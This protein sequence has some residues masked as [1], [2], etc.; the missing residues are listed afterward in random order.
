MPRNPSRRIF[1]ET[2]GEISIEWNYL[3]R[4]LELIAFFYLKGDSET[5]SRIFSGM[6]SG[7]FS[8]FLTYLCKKF[9]PDEGI[10]RHVL[11]SVA[12]ANILRENR[13][14]IQHAVPELS[15]DEKYLGSVHKA[16][17]I[18]AMM[19]FEASIDDLKQ[20]LQE[21]RTFKNYILMIGVCI[22][23]REQK[24]ESGEQINEDHKHFFQVVSSIDTPVLPRKINP[25][26]PPED[27]K[28]D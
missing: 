14:I 12:G 23:D 25:L 5:A 27:R 13:N 20:V 21:I 1:A 18:G 15:R 9:E 4:Q 2:I 8:D 16:S 19:T 3:E 10:R 24:S 17:R 11:H 6:G 28:D 7:P 26:Q 22:L